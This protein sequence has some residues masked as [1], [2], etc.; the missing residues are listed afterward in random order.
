MTN[1]MPLAEKGDLWGSAP[2]PEVFRFEGDAWLVDVSHR[3]RKARSLWP[4]FA[5]GAGAQVAP[6]QVLILLADAPEW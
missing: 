6:Q 1:V 2:H 5:I 3:L 4:C